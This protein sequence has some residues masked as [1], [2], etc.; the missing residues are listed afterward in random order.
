MIPTYDV[1]YTLSGQ[2]VEGYVP[3]NEYGGDG[4]YPNPV[5]IVFAAVAGIGHQLIGEHWPA[6]DLVED[7][8]GEVLESVGAGHPGCS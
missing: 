7:L 2:A 4:T 5:L 6:A 1:G 3:I 8:G